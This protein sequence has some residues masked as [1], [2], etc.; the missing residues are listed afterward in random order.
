M[1][2][3]CP[4]LHACSVNRSGARGGND[5]QRRR[6]RQIGSG[7]WTSNKPRGADL[8]VQV[9]R[10]RAL[11]RSRTSR[12]APHCS[13]SMCRVPSACCWS[14]RGVGS[15]HRFAV[16]RGECRFAV[17]LLLRVRG[18]RVGEVSGGPPLLP[19]TSREQRQHQARRGLLRRRRR[20][21][22]DQRSFER[23][24]GQE[25]Q[26]SVAALGRRLVRAASTVSV[27]V[28]STSARRSA[29]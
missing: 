2:T 20:V 14:A 15:R 6:D 28:W 29:P 10:E 11:Q 23:H 22:R 26:L 4:H 7:G 24:G 1:P 25:R 16:N 17:G 21:P 13:P 5:R 19:S 18:A 12:S 9:R 27:S 3:S 8:G